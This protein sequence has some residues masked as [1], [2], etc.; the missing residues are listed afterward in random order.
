MQ[1]LTDAR[2]QYIKN[3]DGREELYDLEDDAA[4]KK[5]I[6]GSEEGRGLLDRFA[7]ETKAPHQR[8]TASSDAVKYSNAIHHR[9][10]NKTALRAFKSF[11]TFQS[12][13]SF[14]RDET[15]TGTRTS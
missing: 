14:K 13:K 11:K 2:Y 3:G 8:T 12:F 7:R 10:A 15:I 1:S 5:N 6:A 9:D 4:G